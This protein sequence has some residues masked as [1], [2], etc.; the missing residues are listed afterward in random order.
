VNDEVKIKLPN[1]VKEYEIEKIS[2]KNIFSLK[3]SIRT[4]ADFSFH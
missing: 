3:K 2:Y 1:A 4:K